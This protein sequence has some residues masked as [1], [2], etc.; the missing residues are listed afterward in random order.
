MNTKVLVI[1][2][3]EIMRLTLGE[4]LGDFGYDVETASDG[5][6]GI[7]K[8]KEFRPDV[9]L[10]DMRLRTE[11]GLDIARK[12]KQLDEYVEII[13]MTAY[14]DI[15]TAIEAIRIGAI[16]YIKKPLDI[17]EIQV[18]ISKAIASQSMKKKLKL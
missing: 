16:D 5:L 15:K 4:G 18:T 14:G 7:K 8:L 3:E 12:I 2:D 1:D 11:N 10:L 9:I 17:E 13:I 6:E